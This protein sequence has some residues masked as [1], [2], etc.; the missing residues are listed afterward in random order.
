MHMSD[1]APQG[2]R[3]TLG[4]NL[5]F[6]S[7][8][9]ATSYKWFILLFILLPSMVDDMVEGGTKNTAWGLV[10][11]TGAV[12]ALIGPAI[13]G[14]L[15]ET[16]GRRW[17]STAPWLLLG[18]A[19]TCIA[20]FTIHSADVLW[21]LAVGYFLLQFGDDLGTGP[22]AGMVASN[23]PE[24][25]R[26]YASSILG[27]CK[28]AGQIGSAVAAV[29]LKRP[30]LILLG[31]ALVNVLAAISTS[32][33]IRSIPPR[34]EPGERKGF[35][36]EYIEPFGD[37]DFRIVW[38]NR[39]IVSFAFACVSAYTLNFL[40][41]MFTEYRIFGLNLGSADNAAIALALTISFAGILGSIFSARVSDKIG[42]KPLL[43][44]SGIIVACALIPIGFLPNLTAIF[45][46]VLVFGIGNGIYAAA[47]WALV[48]D[49]L[50][51]GE[52][53]AT[54]MGA[55]QSSETAVQIP[56]GILMGLLIDTLNRIHFGAGYQAMIA[57][58]GTLFFGSIFLV[59]HI[60]GGH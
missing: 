54:E 33:T 8:W 43:V 32:I 14:R 28:L 6:S 51:K 25:H 46:C 15:S 41:D 49:I 59:K 31:I 36:Q 9:F 34:P 18:S 37:H 57:I 10:L 56:A 35:W 48:S 24:E 7:Y 58:A 47:D 3:H 13:F 44:R 23:V 50:P 19:M 39:V 52:K 40:K 22:Y 53:A 20:L 29:V 26:G 12:W 1:T 38:L 21:V 11:G 27:A 17:R 16:L 5:G 30:E 45:F 42:R 60:R 2:Y 55:W 4:W